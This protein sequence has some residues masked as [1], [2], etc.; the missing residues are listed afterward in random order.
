MCG[1]EA[2]K[3]VLVNHITFSPN[4]DRYVMLFR[5]F[6]ELVDGKMDWKTSLIAGDRAGNLHVVLPAGMFSHYYWKNDE[7]LLIYC[8][9]EGKKG[10]YL[11]NVQTGAWH[12]YD[13]PFFEGKGNRDIHCSFSPDGNYIIGDGYDFGGYRSL[14]GYSMRTGVARELLKARTMPP[15][16]TDV[17]CDL[18]AQFVWGGKYISYDTT[19]N[20]K[21]E[22]ALI[23]CDILNF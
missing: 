2:G 20:G 9:V 19:E 18:H 16:C 3:K 6:P 8:A 7:E 1:L 21:R 10:M 15:V 13:D 4:S 5:S 11:V 12:R 22:I 17:R 14:Q 23:P